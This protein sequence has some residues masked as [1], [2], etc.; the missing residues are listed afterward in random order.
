MAKLP[1]VADDHDH[2]DAV[3]GPDVRSFLWALIGE[4]SSN[5]LAPRGAIIRI[6]SFVSGIAVAA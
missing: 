1:Y 4:F 6:G 2:P 3:F 5:A